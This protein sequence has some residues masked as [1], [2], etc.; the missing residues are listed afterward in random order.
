[1]ED[2]K[3]IFAQMMMFQMESQQKNEERLF[4]LLQGNKEK[5]K[6]EE[7]L[8][9]LQKES[10][11]KQLQLQQK[12]KEHFFSC[13][14]E[15]RKRNKKTVKTNNGSFLNYKNNKKYFLKV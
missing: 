14:T 6:N 8:L 12:T 1:M 13:Y 5:E 7:K 10:E 3:E 2:L 9:Q 4:Q 11:E 15:K